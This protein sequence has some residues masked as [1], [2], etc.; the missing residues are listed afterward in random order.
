MLRFCQA[1]PKDLPE[2]LELLQ[3]ANLPTA[4][5]EAHFS[6]FRLAFEDAK[7]VGCAGLE[8]HGSAGLLRSV[9]VQPEHRSA[10]TGDKLTQEIIALAKQ[11]KL[12]SLSLLTTTAETYFPRFGFAPVARDQ[13]PKELLISEEFKG[14][15]PDTAV[16]MMLML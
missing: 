8:A 9:A 11:K 4:G 15:C 2:V 14:A 12:S 5:V 6:D 3:T 10:G 1:S 13:L 7:L 16:S